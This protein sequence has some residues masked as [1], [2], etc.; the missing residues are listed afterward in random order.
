MEQ[1]PQVNI[2][3]NAWE[4]GL[5]WIQKLS[6]ILSSTGVFMDQISTRIGLT[7]PMIY[8]ANQ[9]V[10]ILLDKGLW[11]YV[12]ITIIFMMILVCKLIVDNWSFKNRRVVFLGPLTYGVLKTITGIRNLSLYLSLMGYIF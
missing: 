7:H 4:N 11:F 10:K 9:N 6:Y 3:N 8:E 12:D 5:N 2:H 1:N